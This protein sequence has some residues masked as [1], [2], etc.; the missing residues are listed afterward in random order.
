MNTSDDSA[1]QVHEILVRERMRELRS[2]YG[3]HASRGDHE[4]IVQLF[5]PDGIFECLVQE[6][7]RKEFRGHREI[8]AFL[9]QTMYPGVVFPMIHNDIVRVSAGEAWGTCAMESRTPHPQLP[10]FSGYYH[11]R[12]R[13]FGGRWLFT[14]RRYFRYFPQFERSGLDFE[15]NPE[16]GLATQHDRKPG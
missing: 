16:A 4:A 6:R 14:E 3:W 5:A 1:A 7:E 9:Q 8:S 2:L 10:A 15:G 12:A 13:N 11:D